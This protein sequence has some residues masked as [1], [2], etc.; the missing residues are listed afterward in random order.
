MRSILFISLL[1]LLLTACGG[2]GGGSG[3]PV[4]PNTPDTSADDT[5]ATGNSATET[6]TVEVVQSYS[7]ETNIVLE[8]AQPGAT[9]DKGI[10]AFDRDV[11]NVDDYGA[12]GFADHDPCV[13]IS[14]EEAVDPDRGTVLQISHSNSGRLAGMFFESSTPVNLL[15][16]ETGS[17]KFDIKVISGD[18]KITIKVDCGS[19]CTSGE[20][21]L[22][23]KG[24]NGWETVTIPVSQLKTG[25]LNL[26]GVTTGLVIFATDYTDTVFQL[27]NINWECEFTC[28]GELP[29]STPWE[30]VDIDNGERSPI[31][32]AGY[33]LVWS[34]EFDGS[35]VDTSKWGFDTG[36]VDAFNNDGWGNQELQNY[37]AENASVED[38]LLSITAKREDDGTYSSARLK[39]MDKFDF[40]YGR[41]DIRVATAEGKGFWSA[42]WM[43][44]DNYS[45]IGWP[46]AGEIDILDTIGGFRFNRDQ[47]PMIVNNLH[48]NNGGV[49][50]TYSPASFNVDPYPGEVW[51]DE[52]GYPEGETFSNTFHVVSIIWDEDEIKWL[53][54]DNVTTT[55]SIT[56]TDLSEAFR[57]NFF[58]IMNVAIGGTWPGNPD[59]TTQFPRGM[60][61]DYVRV[62][63]QD[64]MIQHIGN[65]E[66]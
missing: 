22:G 50:G 29:E 56:S 42:L 15:G 19:N 4:T 39:T 32:Y 62:F 7:S 26:A 58:L 33:S 30:K 25:G 31:T 21:K 48:W 11:P 51:L 9:W 16:A 59:S 5:D 18:A 57:N 24:K 12:C 43:M 46:K 64:Q 53:V 38:G 1:S 47:E 27:D 14:W 6:S 17:L 34:D 35:E 63:Q 40:M 36:T 2:G 61:V 10:S 28:S 13:N 23:E 45:D 20:Q 66:S 49:N 44:G 8:N 52:E 41:V 54:D 55:V 65:K 60:L 3:S 37:K